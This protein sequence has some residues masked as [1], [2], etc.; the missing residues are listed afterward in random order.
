[1]ICCGWQMGGEPRSPEPK[2]VL[3]AV[4]ICH[5]LPVP[6]I[7]QDHIWGFFR[8]RDG[9]STWFAQIFQNAVKDVWMG[10]LCILTEENGKWGIGGMRNRAVPRGKGLSFWRKTRNEIW[11]L[12]FCGK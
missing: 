12:H 6:A 1:M 3:F 11:V 4:R 2:R 8:E 9:G 7:H 10:F 5:K